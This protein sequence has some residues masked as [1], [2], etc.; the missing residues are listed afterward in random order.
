MYEIGDKYHVSGLKDLVKH[1]FELACAMYWDDPK[2]AEAANYAFSTTPDEDK[3]LRTIVC[4][5]L[6]DHMSLLKKPEVEA[7]MTEFNG[8]S[9]GLLLEKAKENGWLY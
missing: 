4:K 9:F 8:L 3:G 6:S 1:K 2:F 7:L 5:T